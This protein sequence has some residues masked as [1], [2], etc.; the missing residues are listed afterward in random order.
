MKNYN[1][2]INFHSRI[3]EELAKRS[4]GKVKSVDYLMKSFSVSKET[5]YR[6]LRN[7][8]PFS[9][10]EVAAI[11]SDLNTSIDQLLGFKTNS[12]YPFMNRFNLDQEPEGIYADLLNSDI[13]IVEKLISANDVKIVAAIN[14][15]PLQLL[16]YK[17]LFK[18]DYYHYMYSIGKISLMTK[19][20][21]ITVPPHIIDLHKKA[22]DCFS[23]LNNITC[24]VDN[25][26][27]S[28]IIKKIQYYYRSKFISDEDLQILQSELLELLEVYESLLRNGKNSAGSDYVFYYSFFRLESSMVFFEYDDNSIL[29]I[30]IYPESPIILQNNRLVNDVQKRWIS[31]KIRNSVLIT[32]T[33]DIQQIEMLRDVYRQIGELR[34]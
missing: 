14:R 7:Q 27:F 20:S 25:T 21:D 5:A 8:I 12:N 16:H 15:L 9:L 32:K 19:Y 11:A 6:R 28:D 29:E 31:S 18:L 22:F 2:R 24:I 17:S 34:E 26:V 30:R 13:E 4:A 1:S 23:K 33:A 3:I 10:E